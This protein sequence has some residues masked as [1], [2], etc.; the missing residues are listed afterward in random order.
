MP[1][2]MCKSSKRLPA[3]C[4]FA[5]RKPINGDDFAY[6]GLTEVQAYHANGRNPDIQPLEASFTRRKMSGIVLW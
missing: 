1:L 4:R 5:I 3:F 6:D 2:L